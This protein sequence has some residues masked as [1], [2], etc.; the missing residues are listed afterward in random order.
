MD[1]TYVFSFG[2]G[3]TI[4][5]LS[6][7]KPCI[8]EAERLHRRQQL[9]KQAFLEVSCVSLLHNECMLRIPFCWLCL[10][11]HMA[12]KNLLQKHQLVLFRE[13]WPKME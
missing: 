3:P 11:G 8:Q 5:R 7:C 6:A 1:V 4:N 2:G 9:E 10:G 12:C 13:T